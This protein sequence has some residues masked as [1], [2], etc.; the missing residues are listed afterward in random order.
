MIAIGG[1]LPQAYNNLARL[2]ISEKEYPQAVALLQQGIYKTRDKQDFPSE[3]KYNLFKNLG[4]ARV[5]QKRFKD[6]EI[7]LNIAIKTASKPEATSYIG[8][9]GS[10]HCL[11][12][13]ALE[14]QEKSATKEWE[15]CRQKAKSTIPE[16]DTW[17]YLARTKLQE[18]K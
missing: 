17:L 13:Q 12:A 8:N 14:Q 6:A 11:L 16:E 5:E 9:P 10:A 7:P 4:W 1:G 3:D 2:N 15:Q 18:A